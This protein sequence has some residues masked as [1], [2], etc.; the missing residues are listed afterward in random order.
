[1]SQS[2]IDSLPYDIITLILSFV[3]VID[4][5]SLKLAG[6]RRLTT[7]VRNAYSRFSRVQYLDAITKQDARQRKFK[8]GF[9]RTPMEI[10]I[11]RGRADLYKEAPF[12]EIQEYNCQLSSEINKREKSPF[13][14]A[15]HWAVYYG[16]QE[17]AMLLLDRVNLRAGK[18]RETPL[19]YAAKNNQV[20]MAEL[21]LEHGAYINSSDDYGNTPL[22]TALA[23]QANDVVDVLQSRGALTSWPAIIR[24][25]EWAR[26]IREW[27][28]DPECSPFQPLPLATHCPNKM[29][30]RC[31]AL[32][33]VLEY[34]H[35]MTFGKPGDTAL[36]WHQD[37]IAC[38]AILQN[39]ISVLEMLLHE[40]W[41]ARAPNYQGRTPLGIIARH[42]N[43]AQMAVFLL[44][45]G[46]DPTITSHTKKQPHMTPL[47]N[48]LCLMHEDLVSL[49]NARGYPLDTQ[50]EHGE[51]ALHMAAQLGCIS[52]KLLNY[53]LPLVRIIDH[54]DNDGNTPFHHAC[55]RQPPVP[56]NLRVLL[57]AGAD[58]NAQGTGGPPI[59]ALFRHTDTPHT[60]WQALLLLLQYGA[61]PNAQGVEGPLIL[62]L[63]RHTDSPHAF[64][65]ALRLLLQYGADINARDSKGNT[66]LHPICSAPT[67]PQNYST[68]TVTT[69]L[70]ENGADPNLPNAN[71]KYPL[72]CLLERRPKLE[73]D[74]PTHPRC[75]S[76]PDYH[77]NPESNMPNPRQFLSLLDYHA[78]PN[79]RD[80]RG[81]SPLHRVVDLGVR[82][83]AGDK[84]SLVRKLL[85]KG[86][87]PNA[88]DHAGYNALM[89]AD[90]SYRERQ[91][92]HAVFAALLE[93]LLR[94]GASRDT[95]SLYY[96]GWTIIEVWEGK[97]KRKRDED[98]GTGDEMSA[99]ASTSTGVGGFWSTVL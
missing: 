40:G 99:S 22:A 42:R 45:H 50:T 76:L 86:A 37:D 67:G 74:M 2:A 32:D 48:A 58:P 19:H 60:I 43:R 35:F 1:M 28:Y 14:L 57:E 79:V 17:I 27:S 84:I 68:E 77:S 11:E 49:Y 26:P 4:F 90:W 91:I 64:W 65:Q 70:L 25:E 38:D 24:T 3:P 78:D 96:P 54:R 62:A 56:D 29:R 97:H 15:L 88:V 53:L 36:K 46:A 59:L 55:Q 16:Q 9:G 85:E 66:L 23:N 95:A 69:I 44:D 8:S 30:S 75:L 41:D 81:R 92:E 18:S 34:Y 6:D 61:D 89:F 63:S 39:E 52:N 71:G 21:L 94:Y 31:F 5:Y 72:Q 13:S 98:C 12:H 83:A 87:D 51:T 33:K 20:R 47:H 7:A 80:V 93:L 73:S 82:M 10:L